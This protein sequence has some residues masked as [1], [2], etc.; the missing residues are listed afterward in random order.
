MAAVERA[1]KRNRRNNIDYATC[2]SDVFD[3]VSSGNSDNKVTA[4]IQS[5]NAPFVTNPDCIVGGIDREGLH[6]VDVNQAQIFGECYL[7][8]L[9][10]LT[11]FSFGTHPDTAAGHVTG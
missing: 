1:D 4:K 8:S 10:E 6:F 7:S 5:A 2:K 9:T 11:E 3:V